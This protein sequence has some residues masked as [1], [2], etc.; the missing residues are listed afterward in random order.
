MS[1]FCPQCGA[2]RLGA[3]RFCRQC[4]FD[5]ESSAASAT[6]AAPVL[7]PQVVPGRA[8]SG[9]SRWSA[10]RIAAAAAAV[11]L[12]LAVIGNLGTP[13]PTAPAGA[14]GALEAAAT[15]QPTSTAAT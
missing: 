14:S 9:G 10:K 13:H 3:F 15:L 6:S 2:A 5:F 4:R 11:V 8:V 12:G 1:E 7:P